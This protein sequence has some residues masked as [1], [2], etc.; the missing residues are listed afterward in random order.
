MKE[1]AENAVMFVCKSVILGIAVVMAKG[2]IDA[3]TNRD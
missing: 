1:L 2:A 3:L